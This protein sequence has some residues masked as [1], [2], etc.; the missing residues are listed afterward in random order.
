M[1][2]KNAISSIEKLQSETSKK[3]ELKIYQEFIQL[4]KSLEEREFSESE[5][6]EI[7]RELGKLDL[8]SAKAGSKK[9]LSSALNQ[10]KKYLKKSL[11]LTTKSYY[12]N[13]GVGLGSS[14]G[15]IFGVVILSSTER[16]LGISLG[17][18]F[19]MV[20]GLIVGKTLDARAQASGKTI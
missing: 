6:E 2:L 16:S 3:S 15:I 12:T 1:E 14:F 4:L 19:G 17:L 20:L 5:S 11:S 18:S 10:F 9:H 7:E 8:N 13:L